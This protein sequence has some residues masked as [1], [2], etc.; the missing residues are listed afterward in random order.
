MITRRTCV[1]LLLVVFVGAASAGVMRWTGR[2]PADLVAGYL[3]G[4]LRSVPDAQVP[5]ELEQLSRLGRIGVLALVDA[6]G[7]ERPAV[8]TSAA[9]VLSAQVDG[10]RTLPPEQSSGRVGELARNLARRVD[11]WPRPARSAAGDLALQILDW[12]ID[13]RHVDRAALIGDCEHVLRARGTSMTVTTAAPERREPREASAAPAPLEDSRLRPEFDLSRSAIPGGNLPVEE[14]ELPGQGTSWAAAAEPRAVGPREPTLLP[15][16]RAPR[17]PAGQ[18]PDDRPAAPRMLSER[19]QADAASDAHRSP[20]QPLS[21]DATLP[22]DSNLP[23][24]PDRAL[25]SYLDGDDMPQAVQ[26]EEILARRGYRARELMLARGLTSPRVAD[27]LQLVETVA[28]LPDA[29]GR[30]LVWLSQDPD[31]LVRDA[32]VSRMVT[33]QD[34]RVVRRL[35]E[36]E[37]QEADEGIRQQLQRWRE[38][39]A[40]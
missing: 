7:S 23:Q 25:F 39:H 38:S 5:E 31:P 2:G 26:A 4:H 32:A 13:I 8:A 20:I 40:R 30:W 29:A 11:R 35:L 34:P 36:M 14:A 24:L 22:A 17:I 15:I 10:W 6:L 37:T 27:R 9:A 21:S 3:A 1:W 12:P 33:A 16:P 18:D 19:P 28:G